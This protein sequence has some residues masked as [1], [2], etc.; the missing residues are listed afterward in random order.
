MLYLN[1]KAFHGNGHGNCYDVE[2]GEL[3]WITGI[4]RKATTAI[5]GVN[6]L[7]R[8]KK[9]P[10]KNMNRLQGLKLLTTKIIKS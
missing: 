2:T 4:K 1:G 3:Y 8:L 7:F 6:Q 9:L 10:L 5:L